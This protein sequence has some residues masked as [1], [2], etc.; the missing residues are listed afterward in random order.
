MVT[1]P[2][3]WNDPFRI[4]I[5]R[6]VF[7]LAVVFANHLGF[8]N[9]PNL[10]ETDFWVPAT[11]SIRKLRIALRLKEVSLKCN[12]VQQEAAEVASLLHRSDTNLVHQYLP[13]IKTNTFEHFFNFVDE[14]LK[15]ASIISLANIRPEYGDPYQ[16]EKQVSP[17]RYDQNAQDILT[18]SHHTVGSKNVSSVEYVY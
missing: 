8:G 12:I 9:F 5:G 11:H 7:R 6:L 16:R 3:M 18:Y 2:S 13:T 1:T 10:I 14:P 4:W 17:T 15:E